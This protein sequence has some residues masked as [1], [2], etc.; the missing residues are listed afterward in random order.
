MA[1]QDQMVFFKVKERNNLN[2][3][4]SLF[5]FFIIN[6]YRIWQNQTNSFNKRFTCFSILFERYFSYELKLMC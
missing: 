3:V 5:S 2:V 1:G 4:H 6:A